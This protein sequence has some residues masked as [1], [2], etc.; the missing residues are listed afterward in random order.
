MSVLPCKAGLENPRSVRTIIYKGISHEQTKNQHENV[1]RK[2][3][4]VWDGVCILI[5][6]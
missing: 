3:T 1:F 6:P 4:P 5:V 2:H